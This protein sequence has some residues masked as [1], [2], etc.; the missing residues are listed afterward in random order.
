MSIDLTQRENFSINQGCQCSTIDFEEQGGVVVL[1]TQNC[2]LV[3]KPRKNRNYHPL[4]DDWNG[5]DVLQRWPAHN[6]K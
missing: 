4:T 6:E 1:R 2:G 3:M 5:R